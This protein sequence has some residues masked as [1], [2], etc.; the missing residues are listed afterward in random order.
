VGKGGKREKLKK[1]LRRHGEQG[2]KVKGRKERC[3][4]NRKKER[5]TESKN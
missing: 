2:D 1:K 3:I 4:Q 5:K